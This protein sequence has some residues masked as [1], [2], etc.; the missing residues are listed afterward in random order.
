MET[1]A[2]GLCEHS[3]ARP[4]RRRRVGSRRRARYLAPAIAL[5]SCFSGELRGEAPDAR[6]S[7][8]RRPNIL[9]ISIDTL[10]A[11]HL[12]SY[13]YSRE[14]AP[15][16][17]RFAR[18]GA[19]FNRSW[20]QSSSTVPTHASLLTGLWPHQH[21]TYVYPE[22][23]PDA[24]H[25]LAEYLAMQGYRTFCFASS[26]RFH[27]G[28]G[29]H[30]G[31]ETAKTFDAEGKNRRSGLV[32]Q[33]TFRVLAKDDPRPFFGFLHYFDAHEPYAPP[34]PWLRRWHPGL[35]SPRPEDTSEFLQ[36]N[37]RPIRKLSPETLAYLRGL[38]D[39]AISY[40]DSSISEL[41]EGLDERGLTADTL[42]LVTSD[43]GEE[44]KEHGGLSHS[45]WLHEELLRVPL[46]LRWPGRIAGGTVVE[47][48]IQSVD[49]FPTLG[50]LAGLPLPSGLVG[51]SFAADVLIKSDDAGL[52]RSPRQEAAQEVVV[53]QQNE[54]T[55]AVSATLATGRFKY[56]VH[57]GGPPRL[58]H[59]D[60][61]PLGL[62][63]LGEGYGDEAEELRKIAAALGVGEAG[64]SIFAPE[65]KE[66]DPAVLERLRAIGYA[67]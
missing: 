3:F 34:E 2:E 50:E 52:S 67:E 61:D 21:Q 13:G 59:L 56:S 53:H 54:I 24:A 62:K 36:K 51:R 5:L 43:H 33:N 10:R 66:I 28:S 25:T 39:G 64:R 65:V 18:E 22:S 60:R 37:R 1:G 14:T 57:R 63:P 38:Y 29:F 49:V 45:G 31:C 17:S 32:N 40:Q 46:L 55:W 4:S 11:D 23:L 27:P 20:S 42:I 9:L 44:F 8:N 19:Q 35:A 16:L 30:Q 26:T 15:T 7:A 12:A 47:R 58:F 41:L 6:V 48:A